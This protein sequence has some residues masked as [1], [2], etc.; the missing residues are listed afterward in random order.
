MRSNSGNAVTAGS[1]AGDASRR[2]VP[3]VNR[4]AGTGINRIRSSNGRGRSNTPCRRI[5]KAPTTWRHRWP[6]GG[7]GSHHPED[8][9]PGRRSCEDVL[10]P[11]MIAATC[12]FVN[13]YSRYNSKNFGKNRL[14]LIQWERLVPYRSHGSSGQG[15][16]PGRVA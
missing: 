16:R 3:N 2:S 8:K 12:C 5:P 9:V 4:T 1:P 15:I 13:H 11:Q 10:Q 6:R 7:V 14:S